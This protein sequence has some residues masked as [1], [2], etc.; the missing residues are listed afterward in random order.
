[1]GEPDGGGR[2]VW[3]V[4]VDGTPRLAVDTVTATVWR[5][6]A[7]ARDLMHLYRTLDRRLA[8]VLTR[9]AEG[10]LA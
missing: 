10:V 9:A 2:G 6:G 4:V 7:P 3:F 5:P 1:M 8:P